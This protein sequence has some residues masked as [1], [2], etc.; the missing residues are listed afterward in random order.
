MGKCPSAKHP[1]PGPAA[2]HIHGCK[3]DPLG[4]LD[5]NARSYWVERKTDIP[6][7]RYLRMY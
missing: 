4:R 6:P 5:P 1:G 7:A 3:A 2:A